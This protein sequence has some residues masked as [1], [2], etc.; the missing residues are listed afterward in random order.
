MKN[1]LLLLLILLLVLPPSS[2]AEDFLGAPIP[3]QH[4]IEG[5]TDARLEFKTDLSPDATVS[6]YKEKF[7]GQQDIKF[8]DKKDSTFIE[9]HGNL[10]WHSITISKAHMEGTTVEIVKDNWTWIIGTLTLRY[11]GVFVVLMLIFLT[12]ALS[13]S[14]ISRAIKRME[15]KRAS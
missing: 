5:K 8:R 6:Y 4:K 13:G 15:K 12:L 1:R 9:D 7:K 10:P 2:S 11:V 3:P 14:I